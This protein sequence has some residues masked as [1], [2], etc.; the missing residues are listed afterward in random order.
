MKINKIQKGFTLIELMIT[1]AIVGIL[2]A[3]ALPAYSDYTNRAKASEAIALL[4]G[5]KTAAAETYQSRGG[6]TTPAG[7]LVANITEIGGASSAGK[8]I[9]SVAAV[10]DSSTLV[11]LSA[12]F[13]DAAKAGSQLAATRVT[14][15]GDASSGNIIWT[16]GSTTVGSVVTN[17]NVKYLPST[18]KG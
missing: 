8:Y 6:F 12:T 3:V 7:A 11:V 1:V 9:D 10:A 14:M 16:C 5:A 4:N 17:T 18:C 2:S 13:G 15:V